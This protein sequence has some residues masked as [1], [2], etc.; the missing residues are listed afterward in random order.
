MKINLCKRTKDVEKVAKFLD[1]N[2]RKVKIEIKDCIGMCD[3]CDKKVVAKVD[4][5]KVTA[6]DAYD[7]LKEIKKIL[8]KA[9]K[10]DLLDEDEMKKA[11]K[12]LKQEK[13]EKD[14]KKDKKK[15]NK[16]DKKKDKSDEKD[17][18]SKKTRDKSEKKQ[19]DAS[20]SADEQSGYEDLSVESV[21]LEDEV[22]LTVPYQAYSPKGMSVTVRFETFDGDY[23]SYSL[24]PED[25][26]EEEA[27]P[28]EAAEMD[29][30]EHLTRKAI[31]KETDKA[32]VL[33]FSVPEFL[34]DTD[35][36]SFQLPETS[37][38]EPA[39]EEW[40]QK[41]EPSEE[42]EFSDD[43]K[44]TQESQKTDGLDSALE[45]TDQ[46]GEYNA[47]QGLH[48]EENAPRE[49]EQDDAPLEGDAWEA[50]AKEMVQEE[51]ADSETPDEAPIPEY[52]EE[53]TI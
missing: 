49:K 46:P 2:L 35:H 13:S 8:K 1:R 18:K 48:Q 32:S 45:G 37:Q 24:A 26:T 10:L 21:I 3:D 42:A 25:E 5:E 44:L 39:D 23:L 9:D 50:A 30:K 7:L 38:T 17:K 14:K 11:K 53:N 22:I 41:K 36:M 34:G 6:K 15:D 52:Q 12:E 28:D 31:E 20:G 4:G 27:S 51:E 16:K 40:T 29:I 19:S 43:E 33:A 47:D